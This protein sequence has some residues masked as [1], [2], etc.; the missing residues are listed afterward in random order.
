MNM[1]RSNQHALVVSLAAILAAGCASHGNKLSVPAP[2]PLP[3]SSAEPSTVDEAS[4]PGGEKMLRQSPITPPQ[5]TGADAAGLDSREDLPSSLKGAPIQINVDSLPLPAFVNLVLGSQ[6]GMNFQMEDDVAK[7]TDLVTLRASRPQQPAELFLLARQ[8]LSQFGV[9]LAIEGDLIRV[10]LAK[11][12]ASI[13]PP[14]VLSG[15]A[16]PDVPVSH[17]PVFY[18]MQL[19]V[20]RANE[21]AG[22]LRS[23]F[24]TS[25][26]LEE[27]LPRNAVMISGRPEQIKQAVAALKTLD[28]PYLRGRVS[29]RLEPAFLSAEELASRLVDALSAEGFGASKA[30][31]VPASIFVMPVNTVNT[32]LVFASSQSSLERA[33]NWAKELDRPNPA[34]AGRSLFYHQVKNTKADSIVSVLGG[35]QQSAPT[36]GAD[37]PGGDQVAQRPAS[38]GATAG[39][40]LTVDTPRNA[41]IFQG[42]AAEWE[43][44]LTLIRQMDQPARQVMIEVTIAEI[45]LDDN[46]EFGVSWFAKS[47]LGR[48]GG[49]MRMGTLPTSTTPANAPGLTYLLNVAGQNRAALRAFAEDQRVS[50]LSTPRLLVK[51]GEEASIDV[52]TEVP[53]ITAQTTSDQES[54]G[55]TNL[56]QSIQ[57]RKTGIILNVVPTVYSDDRIDLDIRQEVS[58]ALPLSDGASIGSPS[59][60]NRAVETSLSLKDG[61]SIMIGGL[62]SQR[63]TR[64]DSGIPFLKDA[65]LIGN[66]FKS[67]G[68][69]KNKT[70]LIVMIV[71]YI[72]ETDAR[73]REITDAI[74]DSLR[75]LDISTPETVVN[76]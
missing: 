20:I 47:P 30:F 56:L 59:I 9:A 44:L 32:V 5:D 35:S 24:G 15:R 12:G 14:I 68:N 54:F 8:I 70:E 72:I 71:P 58:E 27:S 43:R 40:S 67:Q 13:Q 33:I 63:E 46:E 36:P 55:S 37:K 39:Y 23:I 69:R 45:S 51:S 22:W 61:G 66:L 65:P 31:G 41:I 49:N 50:I 28:R 1:K 17:R 7:L 16:L 75:L 52:G 18:L 26:T 4:M 73:A 57:Y 25:L 53:T 64:S 74:G 11:E 19:D 60:F 62:M 6:L 42:D 48:F 76:E 2:L 29:T 38:A 3:P 10:Q 21:A 34:A